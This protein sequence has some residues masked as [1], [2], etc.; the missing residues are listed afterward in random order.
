MWSVGKG[1]AVTSIN[2]VIFLGGYGFVPAGGG[3]Q[4]PS[5]AAVGNVVVIVAVF[6]KFVCQR[7]LSL[8][9]PEGS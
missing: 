1:A 4:F 6:S 7:V 5:A 3:V 9:R 8:G 2:N